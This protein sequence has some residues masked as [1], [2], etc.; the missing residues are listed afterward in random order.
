VDDGIKP[1]RLH[2]PEQVG[3]PPATPTGQHQVQI[4]LGG[5]EVGK[6]GEQGGE[7]FARLERAEVEHEARGQVVLGAE[8]GHGGGAQR[9]KGGVNAGAG[10]IDPVARHAEQTHDIVAGAVEMA[11]TR[12]ARRQ[13]SR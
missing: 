7:I 6:G 11:S 4:G 8:G 5:V 13:E 3:V 9:L 10:H 12:R 1:Q 2:L